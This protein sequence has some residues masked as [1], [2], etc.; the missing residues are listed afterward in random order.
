MCRVRVRPTG[1]CSQMRGSAS[2]VAERFAG[3]VRRAVRIHAAEPPN[4]YF[5]SSV[6]LEI[7]VEV[8]A[9]SRVE[10]RTAGSELR[11][12]GR[13]GGPGWPDR[14]AARDVFRER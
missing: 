9:G 3:R 12:V 13:L 1:D 14:Q 8:P 5:G 6:S 11:G 7:T 10:G 4:Q 2:T